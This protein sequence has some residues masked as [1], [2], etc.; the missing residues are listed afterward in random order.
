MSATASHLRPPIGWPLLPQPDGD[1]VMRF[2]SLAQSVRDNLKVILSTRPGEQLLRPGY[3]AGLTDFLGQPDTITTRRRV[4]D[5]VTEAIGRWE[6]RVDLDRVDVADLPGRSGQ[7][8]VEIAYRLRRTGE[9]RTLGVNL[10]LNAN[11]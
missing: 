9:A 7:L 11:L 8:R 3:G 2:P 6:T 10:E 4:Y 5:R 1:G